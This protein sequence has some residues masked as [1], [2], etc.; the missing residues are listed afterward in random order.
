ML[1]GHQAPSSV[2]PIYSVPQ[3]R[4]KNKYLFVFRKT[5]LSK[6]LRPATIKIPVNDN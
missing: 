3:N 2:S 4:P 1:Q 6:T 5:V